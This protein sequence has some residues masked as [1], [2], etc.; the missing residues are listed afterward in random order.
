MSFG[1]A[2]HD[3]QRVPHR[4]LQQP[5]RERLAAALG[6][7]GPLVVA[8]A[9][10]AV[11]LDQFLVERALDR[12]RSAIGTPLVV[13]RPIS[14]TAWHSM[15]RADDAPRQ[16]RVAGK[17]VGGEFGVPLDQRPRAHHQVRDRRRPA[18]PARAR[19]SAMT[20]SRTGRFFT[21]SPRTGRW[22]RCAPV[23]STAKA[24][25]I[26]KCTTRH[27]L[28]ASKV[29]LSQYR[30]SSSSSSLQAALAHALSGFLQ[31]PARA[32]Q[33]ELAGQPAA[34]VDQHR[35]HG[36]PAEDGVEVDA[37]MHQ[38]Q[39]RSQPGQRLM[40]AQQL[41]RDARAGSACACA[42]SRPWTR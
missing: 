24:S 13:R 10:H 12:C 16:A 18:P 36:Q 20:I 29:R 32:V 34:H 5:V 33:Q 17:A 6:E 3:E 19:L 31:A 30:R 35:P 14:A 2:W 41:G 38:H 15:Q 23:A 4:H 25:V 9:G 11:L 28:T 37:G 22:P 7:L 26:G 8:V 1:A 21:S 39:Q 27:C 40:P 42:A